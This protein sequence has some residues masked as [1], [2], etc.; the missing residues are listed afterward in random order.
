MTPES[1]VRWFCG[2]HV[3]ETPWDEN[4]HRW[5]ERATRTEAALNSVLRGRVNRHH[6]NEVI[7]TM[8][9]L[10]SVDAGTHPELDQN[11]TLTINNKPDLLDRLQAQLTREVAELLAHV[12]PMVASKEKVNA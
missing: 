2:Q 9:E 12:E 6:M 4:P 1:A 3:R 10:E 7:T 8:E 11:R 5:Y